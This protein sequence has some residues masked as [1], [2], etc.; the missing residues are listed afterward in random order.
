MAVVQEE[1]SPVWAVRRVVRN[2]RK[3]KQTD[4]TPAANTPGEEERIGCRS[5]VR[6][7][8]EAAHQWLLAVRDLRKWTGLVSC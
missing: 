7:P 2:R 6:P 3:D 8:G 5:A 1:T 4:G